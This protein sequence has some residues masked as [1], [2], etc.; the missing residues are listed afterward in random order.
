MPPTDPAELHRPPEPA[1]D[2]VSALGSQGRPQE[3]ALAEL[4]GILVRIAHTEVRR[5]DNRL[6]L[7]GPELD[8]LADQAADDALLA[9]TAKL[10]TFRGESQFTTWAYAFVIL[11]VSNKLGR[12]FWRRPATTMETADWDRLPDHLG[13]GPAENAQHRDLL[14]A[15]RQVVEQELTERQRRVFTAI[16]VDGIPLDAL[17]VKLDSNRNALYQTMF[18]ARR[19]IRAALVAKG[20][21]DV[22]RDGSPGGQDPTQA[23]KRS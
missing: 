18:D 1:L 20:Y 11:E 23:V 3:A 22:T 8:D 15:L 2:W 21:L 5:R 19:K 10:H 6:R 14:N 12:H 13:M 7:A 17:A 16:V 4:H 9:I